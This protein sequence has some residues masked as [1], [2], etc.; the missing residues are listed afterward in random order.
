MVEDT[1]AK[2]TVK[3]DALV[4]TDIAN[5]K[6]NHA[7]IGVIELILAIPLVL[8]IVLAGIELSRALR[9]NMTIT[10]LARETATS[11]FRECTPD[12]YGDISGINEDTVDACLTNIRDIAESSVQDRYPDLGINIQIFKWYM[13]DPD[14]VLRFGSSIHPD[15]DSKIS[16][17]DFTDPIQRQ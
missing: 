14:N 12:L 6:I 11:A 10:S 13:L 2:N 9:A 3:M 8:I 4:K 16:E 15:Y 1:T 17:A 5:G 7:G